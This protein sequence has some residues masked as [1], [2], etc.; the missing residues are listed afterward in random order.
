MLF[1]SAPFIF[2]FLPVVLCVLFLLGRLHAHTLALAWLSAASLV[3][4]SWDAPYRL[5]PLILSSIAFNFVVGRLLLRSQSRAIL[6]LGI[7][8][9][10][11]LL[12]YFKYARLMIETFDWATGLTVPIPSIELPIGISFF[13]FTQIAFLVDAYRGEADEYGALHYALFVSFFPHLIAGPIY[14]HRE[15]MPQLRLEDFRFDI[16]RLA[17]GLTWFALGLGKKVIFADSLSQYATPLFNAAAGGRQL[18]MSDSWIAVSSFTLQLYY[19][20]SG[21]SDMAIGLALII[22]VRLPLNFDSPYKARSL[23]E[24][25]RRWHMTLSRFLRD[26]LYI[27]LGGNRKGPVRRYMNLLITMLLGG[28][29]HGAAWTFVLWGGIHGLGLIVNHAWHRIA[30][31]CGWRI[32]DPIAL[33]L[34]LVFVMLAWVPFRAESAS[35]TF[36]MW[37][38]MLGFHD[39]VPA[40]PMQP[41]Q[42]GMAVAAITALLAVALLAPNTQQLLSYP[43]VIVGAFRQKVRLA[44]TPFW[45]VTAG[46]VF[47]ISVSLIITQRPTE[48][49]YFRF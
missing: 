24:F 4:Y 45:A 17:Y 11:L 12:G 5:L 39:F 14:H 33:V 37:K 8:G 7:G 21:Y 3:F 25:W 49:L 42:A 1:N 10:L 26:Y 23:I 16:S 18:S 41:A 20:F 19:D 31:A 13:T 27:P 36:S 43:R 32:A 6:A 35:V 44:P 2:L 15:I 9:D 29:W 22:G 46:I 47:G 40:E 48:F 28:L 38:S 30:R 34:T